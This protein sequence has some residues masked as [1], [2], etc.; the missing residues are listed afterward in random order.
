MERNLLC[1]LLRRVKGLSCHFWISLRNCFLIVS[2]GNGGTESQA[3]PSSASTRL[4]CT[5]AVPSWCSHPTSRKS[6]VLNSF[7]PS[8]T[9]WKGNPQCVDDEPKKEGGCDQASLPGEGYATPGTGAAH[10][11]GAGDNHP[12]P[13][14]HHG[15]QV[16]ATGVKLLRNPEAVQRSGYREP[17]QGT[18]T[19]LGAPA[20]LFPLLQSA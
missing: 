1:F 18:P 10:A 6:R 13:L 11:A 3:I 7:R 14:A 17:H 19:P 15:V 2:P 8:T 12:A 16:H 9:R 5:S 4:L 20:S